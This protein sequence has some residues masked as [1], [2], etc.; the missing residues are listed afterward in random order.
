[1]IGDAG[2]SMTAADK[3]TSCGIIYTVK[4]TDKFLIGHVT[5]SK[6]WSIPKGCMDNDVDKTYKDAAIREFKEETGIDIERP[7]NL[8]FLGKFSY[9]VDKDLAVFLYEATVDEANHLN[10]NAKCVSTFSYTYKV[11]HVDDRIEYRTSELPE[12]DKYKFI[13]IDEC[14]TYLNKAMATII[15]QLLAKK[16]R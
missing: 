8:V 15:K 2:F 12:I 5:M 11:C 1:M 14:D 13:H 9:Q 7:N 6:L 10:N 4:G 16:T 3:Q